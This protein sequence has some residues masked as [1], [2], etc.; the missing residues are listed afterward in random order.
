MS[1][2]SDRGMMTCTP[3]GVGFAIVSTGSM[4]LNSSSIRMD[5]LTTAQSSNR[6]IMSPSPDAKH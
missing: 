3:H 5:S 2:K 1:A 6:D 4:F